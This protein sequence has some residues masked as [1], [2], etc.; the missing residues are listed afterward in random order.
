[1][2]HHIITKL[3]FLQMY[4][5]VINTENNLSTDLIFIKI[6]NVKLLILN[7]VVTELCHN[8]NHHAIRPNIINLIKIHCFGE[9]GNNSIN[10]TTSP[11]PNFLFSQHKTPSK[12]VSNN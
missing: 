9:N 7:L 4:S 3:D 11:L 8:F 12:R 10:Y 1:M 5:G 6:A 2:D